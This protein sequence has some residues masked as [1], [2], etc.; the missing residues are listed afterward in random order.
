MRCK[1][2]CYIVAFVPL[3]SHAIVNVEELRSTPAGD[4]FSGR[5]DLSLSG[6]SGNTEKSSSSIGTRLQWKKER[7]TNLFIMNYAYG[8]SDDIRD[9]N[10]GF[11]HL[12]HIVQTQE[13]RAIETFAQIESNEF[14]RLSFRGLL[15]AG[16]RYTTRQDDDYNI[17]IGLGA[18]HAWE[19]L[20][21]Q[22]GLTDDGTER[23]W[24]ANIYLVLNYRLN[25]HVR[26]GS[27]TYYQPAIETLSDTRILEEAGLKVKLADDLDLKLTLEIVHDSRPPET[28]K[29]TDTSYTTGVEYHF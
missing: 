29:K 9:T 19:T 16:I 25:D 17:H 24:R 21:E 6:D 8:E 14:A 10:K 2:L 20:D 3:S 27:T 18:F 1:W 7:V 12:R 23:F 5:F 11:I 4:G 28:V 26:A 22:T 15:G 13:K